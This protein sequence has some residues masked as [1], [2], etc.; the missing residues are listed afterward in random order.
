MVSTISATGCPGGPPWSSGEVPVSIVPGLPD[1]LGSEVVSPWPTRRLDRSHLHEV[2]SSR[3]PAQPGVGPSVPEGTKCR[4]RHGRSRARPGSCR[5]AVLVPRMTQPPLRLPPCQ[6]TLLRGP[7]GPHDMFTDPW[8][9]VGV[10]PRQVNPDS[11]PTASSSSIC[12]GRRLASRRFGGGLKVPTRRPLPGPRLIQLAQP[13]PQPAHQ[14]EQRH[15][16]FMVLILARPNLVHRPLS[17]VPVIL[18]GHARMYQN[19]LGSP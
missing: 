8:D 17:S 7:R 4:R 3:R 12:G 10:L 13:I 6:S 2:P 9:V 1:R 15:P 16:V 5:R 19:S 18:D 11:A 14:L